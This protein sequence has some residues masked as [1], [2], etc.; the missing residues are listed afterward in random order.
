MKNN[1]IN[2]KF[3]LIAVTFLSIFCFSTAKAN[4]LDLSV[5][6][7]KYKEIWIQNEKGE[8][9]TELRKINTSRQGDI[10]LYIVH[11]ENRG[12][13]K[14]RNIPIITPIPPGT[15]YL[16]VFFEE[17]Q[18][19][20][21]LFSLDGGNNY[22]YPPLT[23]TFIDEQGQSIEREIPPQFYTHIQWRLKEPLLPKQA[24]DFYFKVKVT[25]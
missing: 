20:E 7:M 2:K 22:Y 21:I 19:A 25:E 1:I 4:L 17:N 8:T 18:G 6:L 3:T 10:I 5:Q 14:I 12:N 24:N 13:E 23:Y 16:P 9:V 11:C 15:V